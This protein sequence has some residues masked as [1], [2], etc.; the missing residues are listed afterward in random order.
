[1]A[2]ATLTVLAAPTLSKSFSPSSIVSGG[3]GTTVL[4]ITVNNP[5]G[6]SVTL[7]TPALLDVFPTSP[8]GMLV[9]NATPTNSCGGA[10]VNSANAALAVGNVGIRLNGGTVPPTSSCSISVV[11]NVPIAGN[12]LNNM[13]PVTSTNA[14]SSVAGA[15]ASFSVGQGANLSV[16]KDNGTTSVAAGSTT[17]Y[18]ITVANFGPA[19]ASG[20]SI[21]DVPSAGLNCTDVTCSASGGAA[22][23]ATNLAAFL[24]SGQSIPTFPSG[25]QV[26]F[27]LT[28][29]VTAT[30]Q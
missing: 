9:F 19:D 15:T 23:P 17:S 30:G 22:C 13:P 2:T 18:T 7:A 27:V 10:V 4:T 6:T 3:T 1:V 16:A 28:C 14:G 8:G 21:R 24:G 26:L 20:T 5:N 25:G 11:V 12:Y 29:G